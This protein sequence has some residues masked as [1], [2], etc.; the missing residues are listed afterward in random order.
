[1]EKFGKELAVQKIEI[2]NEP[3]SGNPTVEGAWKL[4][5]RHPDLE[6]NWDNNGTTTTNV[7]A[8]HHPLRS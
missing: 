7:V 1:M 4:R 3:I 5:G 8:S 2:G 6:N